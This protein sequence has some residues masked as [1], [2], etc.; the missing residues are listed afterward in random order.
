MKR[1]RNP[2]AS[3]PKRPTPDNP[4]TLR[5]S[6]PPEPEARSRRPELEGYLIDL[7]L[8]VGRTDALASALV[9]YFDERHLVDAD[10]VVA[11]RR[12]SHLVDLVAEAAVAAARELDLACEA[13][14]A[15]DTDERP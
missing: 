9:R 12:A 2:Q 7:R 11:E 3:V 10:R 1:H 4:S 13:L 14:E 8:A 15:E 5:L 6:A